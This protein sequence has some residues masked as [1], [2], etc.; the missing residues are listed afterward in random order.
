MTKEM[1]AYYN[2]EWLP[3]SECKVSMDDRGLTLGDSVFEVDRTFDGKVFD[4]DG[5]L[6]RLFRSLKFTRIDPGLTREEIADISLEAVERNKNLVPE[7][8]DMTIQQTITIH[9]R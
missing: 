1:T 3:I 5:H 6:D 9:N 8:G 7:G 4:L 2:G